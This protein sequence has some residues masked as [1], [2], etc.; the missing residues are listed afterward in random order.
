[1]FLE[2][3]TLQNFQSF[4]PDPESIRFDER[5]TALLGGNATG[6]TAASQALLRLF[7]VATGQPLKGLFVVDTERGER[8]SA[9]TNHAEARK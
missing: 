6:K 5:L 9:I 7:S 3:L 4:G 1:M 2:R 8:G